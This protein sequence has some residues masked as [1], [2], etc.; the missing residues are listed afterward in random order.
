MD[1]VTLFLYVYR[2]K[3]VKAHF[4]ETIV[5]MIFAVIACCSAKCF[6][7]SQFSALITLSAATQCLGF[8]LLRL[9][10]QKQ[11]GAQ[12]I[13]S[14]A[15]QLFAVMYVS[16]LYSTLQFNGYLPVDRSGDWFYQFIEICALGLVLSLIYTIHANHDRS[17]EKSM[18]TCM[19]YCFMIG[20][21]VV[22][23]F[24]HPHLNNRT[25]PDIAWT[26]ALYLEAVSMV[27]QLWMLVKK[28][29][30]VETLASHYI[31]CVFVSRLLMLTFWF[32]SYVELQPRGSDYNLPGLGVIGAQLLQVVIFA[33]FMYHYVQSI[34][35][36][37]R[38]VLPHSDIAI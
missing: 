17:Y 26:N 11:G 20:A 15:L 6:S 10:I 16:R 31:A 14:R 21:F 19:I 30:E 34:R 1:L 18:D 37:T 28:G 2:H 35:T 36:N 3:A 23:Y 27:P 5:Y 32:N 29:G 25:V 13:S 12:G 7:D 22:S 33:D 38:L 8:A 9:K 24:V 4:H